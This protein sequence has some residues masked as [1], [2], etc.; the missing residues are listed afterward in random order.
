MGA[1][2]DPVDPTFLILPL[3]PLTPAHLHRRPFFN[4]LAG[5]SQSGFVT[6]EGWQISL[7]EWSWKILNEIVY[8]NE[9]VGDLKVT[10][11]V[12]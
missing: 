10:G 2:L 4:C 6:V 3:P 8:T 12:K 1:G 9:R 5:D 7:S 11:V